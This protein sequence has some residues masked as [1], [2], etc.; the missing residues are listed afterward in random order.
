MVT[1]TDIN[2]LK[3]QWEADSCWDIEDTEGF[4]GH[5]EELTAFRIAKETEWE[6]LRRESVRSKAKT[7]K[8]SLE[9][10]LYIEYLESRI[11]ALESAA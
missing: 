4:E 10:A 2:E 5:R 11:D 8:C 1:R 7:L 3:A 9:L 6:Q